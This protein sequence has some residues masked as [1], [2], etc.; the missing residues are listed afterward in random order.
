MLEIVVSRHLYLGV[1]FQGPFEPVVC[2]TIR[3]AICLKTT[4]YVHFRL[5]FDGLAFCF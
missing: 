2:L 4:L 5:G 3:R 1:G